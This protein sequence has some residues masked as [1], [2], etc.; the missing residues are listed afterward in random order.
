MP[1]VRSWLSS[2][3]RGWSRSFSRCPPTVFLR[4]SLQAIWAAAALGYTGAHLA[5]QLEVA[6]I[7]AIT[8]G[9]PMLMVEAWMRADYA[10]ALFP[11][12]RELTA[13]DDQYRKQILR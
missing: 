5:A 10:V 11:F 1:S 9:R 8:P 12:D 7:L 6:P 13:L 2:V 4:L 3:W